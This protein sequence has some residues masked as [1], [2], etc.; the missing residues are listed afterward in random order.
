MFLRIT[1]SFFHISSAIMG[2]LAQSMSQQP[3]LSLQLPSSGG[4][5]HV[6]IERGCIRVVR[7]AQSLAGGLSLRPLPPAD[8]PPPTD[9]S[10]HARAG[11]APSY[12]LELGSDILSSHALLDI[13][14]ALF[15]VRHE[16]E[17]V[18][19]DLADRAL[20]DQIIHSGLGVPSPLNPNSSVLLLREA[21]WQGA[22]APPFCV[23]PPSST[24]PLTYVFTG[25][26]LRHPLREPKPRPGA[27]LYERWISHL[28]QMFS[29]RVVDD[30]CDNDVKTFNE[31]QNVCDHALQFSPL[32]AVTYAHARR[33]RASQQHGL[34]QALSRLI[35]HTWSGKP[36]MHIRYPYSVRL[37]VNHFSIPNS[38]G[39]LYVQ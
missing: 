20:R 7:E 26:G 12:C 4:V 23:T 22:L 8:A 32:R 34:K 2:S 29:L 1:S 25:T 35:G 28:G 39:L 10:L 27:K 21:F 19:V 37:M 5:L 33:I 14:Y 17:N 31:W 24:F 36:P 9:N 16:L 6:F 13:L 38:T 3:T 18:S 15:N 11:L 30:K